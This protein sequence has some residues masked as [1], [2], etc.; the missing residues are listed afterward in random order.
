MSVLTLELDNCG[1]YDVE[2]QVC[3]KAPSL[4]DRIGDALRML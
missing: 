3:R 4:L 1:V 2:P